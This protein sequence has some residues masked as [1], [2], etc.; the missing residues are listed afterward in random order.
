[1]SSQRR[2]GLTRESTPPKRTDET[3]DAWIEQAGS[4]RNA[5]TALNSVPVAKVATDHMLYK[6]A[7]GH[8]CEIGC[9]EWETLNS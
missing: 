4:K 5:V 7:G 6:D 9:G 8:T 1:M 2:S 3:V